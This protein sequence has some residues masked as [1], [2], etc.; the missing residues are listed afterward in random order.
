MGDGVMILVAGALLALALLVTLVAGRLRV[1]GL[2][3]FL[4]LGMSIGSEGLGLIA[5]DDAELAGTIGI[6]AL[7]LILFEGGLAAG[8][9]EVRPVLGVSLSL[10][11]VGTAL[12]AGVTGL[13]AY[14]LLDL[15]P[16]ESFLLGSI[17]AATD[18][19]AIFSVL[20]GSTLER[21]LARTLE[22]ESGFNDPVAIVLVIG[23]IEALRTPGYGA[24]DIGLLIVSELAIGAVVGLA[25]G[26]LAVAAFR[27]AGFATSGLY[28]VASM[29]VAALTYGAADVLHGSGFMAIYLA[30][31]ALGS[32][33]IPASRTIGEFHEGVAW[34]SQIALFLA[35]GLLVF[36]HELVDVAAEG[37]LVAAALTFV[38]RPLA[39]IVATRVG[40]FSL[41]E[42]I[43]VGWAGLKG[44]IP[45]V[46]ATF[47]V[48]A[49]LPQGDR[50]FNLVFFVVLVSALLQGVTFEPLARALG[51]TGTSPAL[52]RQPLVEVGTVRRLGAEVLEYP[53]GDDEAIVGRVVNELG[54]P[55][56][57]LVSFIVRAD[58]ALVPR[59]STQIEAGDRLHILVKGPVRAQVRGLY[60]RWASGPVG[61]PEVPPTALRGSPA[62][63]SVRPWSSAE[64]DPGE[65]RRFGDVAVVRQLRTRRGAAG[66]LVQL[67]DG[68]FAVTGDGVAAIGGSRQLGRYCSERIRR[69]PDQ[70]SRAWWQETAGVLSQRAPR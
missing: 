2:I 34:V 25:L 47:P 4:L 60:E 22:A 57:A 46:L 64:G 55:R 36:P 65:P 13:A 63:F 66:A 49:G 15:E 28:P 61:E 5:F 38:A 68:R 8:W 7:S 48:T 33:R 51:L 12:T 3:L 39:A 1:P 29:A 37:L 10:A 53:V 42:S 11:T 18:S 62:I 67:E 30:G 6:I 17:V 40:R 59:G 21:R 43:L 32:G 26:R 52:P 31:L 19:A 14:L 56:E 69:A 16:L 23:F 54:L 20:R 45:V 35:L 58:E 50:F 70:E 27:R 41:R 44:A 24:L 9:D